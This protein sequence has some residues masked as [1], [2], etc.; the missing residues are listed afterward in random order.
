MNYI[1]IPGLP[2]KNK[3]PECLVFVNPDRVKH[4]VMFFFDLDFEYFLSKDRSPHVCYK[5]QVMTYLLVK[6]THMSRKEVRL[7]LQ[8]KDASTII[9]S[10]RTIENYLAYDSRVKREIKSIIENF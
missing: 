2:R 8:I 6:Y 10:C 3:K 7:L 5:R 9:N 1:T 4:A